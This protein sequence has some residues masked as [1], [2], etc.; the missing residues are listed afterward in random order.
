MNMSFYTAAVGAQ[1]QQNRMN[2]QAN[3]IANVNTYGFKAERPSFAALIYDNI[4]GI[5]G[6]QLPRGNGSYIVMAET[7]FQ[8]GGIVDTGRAQDYAIS[9]SGFFALQDPV[10]GEISF[11]RDGSFTLSSFQRQNENGVMET[12]QRLSDGMGRF[13]LSNEG[14]PIE[15]QNAQE[16]QPVGIFD[17]VNTNGM[18]HVGGN[19]FVPVDKNG[20]IRLG[21][22][23]LINGALEASNTD[24]AYEL[25]KII[26]SQRSFSYALRMVQTSDEIETTVNNLRG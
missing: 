24:L 18:Q 12:V 25:S 16:K 10:S 13:V 21:T 26:E 7:D 6:A 5:D 22:G 15:V 23:T 20:Q 9:G 11:T 17:F 2:I 1:Q 14:I 4:R 8:A 19:R 3:N